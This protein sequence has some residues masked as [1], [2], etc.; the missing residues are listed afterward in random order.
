MGLKQ[1]DVSIMDQKMP[2]KCAVPDPHSGN[3]YLFQ[4]EGFSYNFYPTLSRID[5]QE[6]IQI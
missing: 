6:V 4:R 3:L 1:G 5:P 2:V